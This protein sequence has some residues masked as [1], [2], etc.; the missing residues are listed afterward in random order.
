MAA[1]VRTADYNHPSPCNVARDYAIAVRDN[2]GDPNMPGYDPTL[3]PV[4]F[5]T[6]QGSDYTDPKIWK[7][8]NPNLGVTLTYEYMKQRARRAA[9][10]QWRPSEWSRSR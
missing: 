6:P 3:L 10:S 1:A 9:D 2:P 5:E 4:I 7:Q 8:A